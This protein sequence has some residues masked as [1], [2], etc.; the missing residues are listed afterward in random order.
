[1]NEVMISLTTRAFTVDVDLED[2]ALIEAIFSAL[3]HYVNKGFTLKVR[4]SY[5]TSLSDSLKIITRIISRTAQMDE[6]KS[7]TKQLIS[8]IRKG[9]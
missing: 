4:E 7:E 2:D 8:L 5:V 9:A 6:W 3:T 1:M